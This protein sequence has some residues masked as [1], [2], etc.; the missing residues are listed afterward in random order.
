MELQKTGIV[1]S[2]SSPRFMKDLGFLSDGVPEFCTGFLQMVKEWEFV[3]TYR[4]QAHMAE[5]ATLESTLQKAIRFLR[6]SFLFA[7]I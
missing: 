4:S 3:A 7:Q 5:I 1:C 2:T 6:F